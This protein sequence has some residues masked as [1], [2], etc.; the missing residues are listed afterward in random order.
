MVSAKLFAKEERQRTREIFSV[1][2]FHCSTVNDI[3]FDPGIVFPSFSYIS[4]TS[5]KVF[6]LKLLIATRLV[7]D[8]AR[9][10]SLSEFLSNPPSVDSLIAFLATTGFLAFLT[11]FGASSSD[12]ECSSDSAS[13]LARFGAISLEFLIS[14]VERIKKNR[15]RLK[16]KMKSYDLQSQADGNAR[17]ISM[18]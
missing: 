8:K 3:P 15:T 11:F 14:D 16:S 17:E 18:D 6:P 5:I 9:T 2:I 10:G 12:P 1:K 4:L 7:F 13:F